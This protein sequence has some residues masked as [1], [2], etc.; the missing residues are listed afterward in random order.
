MRRESASNRVRGDADLRERHHAPGA[1][2]QHGR[3]RGLRNTGLITL[4]AH[5]C[6]ELAS[7][8]I[9]DLPDVAPVGA[10]ELD[11][12]ETY[13]GAVLSGLLGEGE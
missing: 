8:V 10:K 9:D 13:L 11:V 12:I 6:P 7:R 2:A 5:Q 3:K 1:V 4:A